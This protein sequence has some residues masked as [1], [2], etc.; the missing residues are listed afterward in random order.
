MIQKPKLT[1]QNEKNIVVRKGVCLCLMQSKTSQV[2]MKIKLKK[3]LTHAILSK[4][5]IC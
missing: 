2:Y 5:K 4:L 1:N 3:K